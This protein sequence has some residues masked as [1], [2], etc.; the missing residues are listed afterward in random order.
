MENTRIIDSNFPILTNMPDGGQGI[1]TIETGSRE[2]N[3]IAFKRKINP[4]DLNY[5]PS[6]FISRD[7]WKKLFEG[8]KADGQIWL[9]KNYEVYGF[10]FCIAFNNDKPEQP[11]AYFRIRTIIKDKKTKPNPIAENT[12]KVLIEVENIA[13]VDIFKPFKADV[14]ISKQQESIKFVSPTSNPTEY[15]MVN[16]AVKNYIKD[17]MSRHKDFTKLTQEGCIFGKNSPYLDNLKIYRKGSKISFAQLDDGTFTYILSINPDGEINGIKCPV[18]HT[19][20]FTD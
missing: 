9:P 11:V 18:P 10:V 19:T 1:V 5:Q 17:P 15:K 6:F 3:I 8:R 7:S 16:R 14:P 13:Y 2:E 20:C 12:I 4:N